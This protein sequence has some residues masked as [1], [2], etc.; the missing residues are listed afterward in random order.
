MAD[1]RRHVF[2][3][4]LLLITLLSSVL[5]ET[6]LEGRDLEMYG[7]ATMRYHDASHASVHR[8]QPLNYNPDPDEI[9]R[10]GPM[11]ERWLARAKETGAM[12]I[13]TDTGWLSKTTYFATFIKPDVD[14]AFA[15]DMGLNRV[16]P[17]VAGGDVPKEAAIFWRHFLGKSTPLKVNFLTYHGANYGIEPLH[18][19]LTA[20]YP[21]IHPL[22]LQ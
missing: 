1:I 2:P 7:Q 11:R 8:Y 16:L 19:V 14:D 13:Q 10:K 4:C 12:H 9:W 15:E 6:P 5:A 18:R 20:L 22:P 21:K 17:S 3:L